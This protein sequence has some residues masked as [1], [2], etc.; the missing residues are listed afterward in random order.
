MFL[1]IQ[2]KG[3]LVWCKAKGGWFVSTGTRQGEAGLVEGKGRLVCFY[4]YKARG[5]WFVCFYQCK[6]RGGWFVCFYQCKARG[7]WF[8]CLF[9]SLCVCLALLHMHV[10]KGARS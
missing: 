3:R 7:G 4:G 5:G 6:A 2:G 9:V 8:V 10:L 1:P